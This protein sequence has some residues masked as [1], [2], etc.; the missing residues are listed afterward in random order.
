M[1]NKSPNISKKDLDSI[2]ESKRQNYIMKSLADN[3]KP[4][5]RTLGW[6]P[7]FITLIKGFVCTAV[8]YLPRA[9]WNGGYI[10][11]AVALFLSYLLTLI[12][13]KKLLLVAKDIPGN[14]SEIGMKLYGTKGRVAAD[15]SIVL[16]QVGFV[17]AYVA[18]ISTSLSE[19]IQQSTGAK[20]PINHWYFGLLCAIIYI[21]L[22]W[23]RN[24]AVF[25]KT[26]LFAD[27]IIVIMITSV[28]VYGI[29]HAVEHGG[30]QHLEPLNTSAFLEMVGFAV[31]SY[32][33]IGIVLPVS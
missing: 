6:V 9:Y 4:E 20:E 2:L 32:E 28:I 8:L 17:T 14:F 27:I 10:F 19:V 29:I 18:F 5:L 13:A 30:G 1:I 33:G 23:V 24:I 25:N 11:S 31:Y 21:P 7:T 16:S 15:V 22:C 12:C 26:H 3:D